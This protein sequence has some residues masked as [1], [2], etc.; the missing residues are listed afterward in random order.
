[1]FYLNPRPTSS[2][3]YVGEWRHVSFSSLGGVESRI[4]TMPSWTPSLNFT[5]DGILG[6]TYVSALVN[7]TLDYRYNVNFFAARGLTNQPHTITITFNQLSFAMLDYFVYT[8][9]TL[10]ISSQPSTSP[11]QLSKA[12][13]R[14]TNV[15]AAV[16]GAVG[17]AVSIAILAALGFWLFR[18]RRRR[19][20]PMGSRAPPLPRL[21]D[22]P[23]YVTRNSAATS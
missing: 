7:T 21:A 16:G 5:V 6:G 14:K 9:P 15:G 19:D 13:G 8:S 2:P 22:V 12:T 23:A 18:R 20:D 17:G 11:L 4:M 10:D 3:D 1:M